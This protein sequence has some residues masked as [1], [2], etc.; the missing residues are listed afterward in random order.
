M[1]SINKEKKL[2]I[3]QSMR[4]TESEKLLVQIRSDGFHIESIVGL[5][6]R[7]Y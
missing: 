6:P 2:I 7:K 4:A 5:F 3:S 1:S